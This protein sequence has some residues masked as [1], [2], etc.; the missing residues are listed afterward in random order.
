MLFNKYDRKKYYIN[1]YWPLLITS[2]QA[3]VFHA[4]PQ[5]AQGTSLPNEAKK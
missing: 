4:L 1:E 3:G 5:C 2:T